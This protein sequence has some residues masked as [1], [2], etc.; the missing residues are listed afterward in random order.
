MQDRHAKLLTD[1]TCS[2][3]NSPYTYS[4]RTEQKADP[5]MPHCP[6]PLDQRVTSPVASHIFPSVR[7]A[8][9]HKH[10]CTPSF[11]SCLQQPKSDL[12]FIMT[13]THNCSIFPAPHPAFC[14]I[15][16]QSLHYQF[17]R[18]HVAGEKLN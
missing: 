15:T 1:R 11:P 7:S 17:Q 16:C 3:C 4:V 9:P 12:G 5:K 18:Y 14:C 8:E 10:S 2:V 6:H 13:D